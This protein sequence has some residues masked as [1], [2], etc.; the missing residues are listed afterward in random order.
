MVINLWQAVDFH[1]W[2]RTRETSL[3]LEARLPHTQVGQ[4]PR[5]RGEFRDREPIMTDNG[6]LTTRDFENQKISEMIESREGKCRPFH[7][8]LWQADTDKIRRF[9]PIEF[10][11][12]YMPGWFDYAFCV[13]IHQLA[14]DKAQGN[15]LNTLSSCTKRIV[16]LTGTLLGG[17]GTNLTVRLTAAC[18]YQVLG[19][20]ASRCTSNWACKDF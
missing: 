12:R 18:F 14:G 19:C 9:A 17:Y 15:A 4:I 2:P 6:R 11:G 5:L 10:I 13:E 7:S 8:P 3:L 1:C 16:G 20:T